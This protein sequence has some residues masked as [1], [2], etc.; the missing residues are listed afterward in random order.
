MRRCSARAGA[1]TPASR[2][3]CR[4][5]AAARRSPPQLQRMAPKICWPR[6]FPIRWRAARTSSAIAKIPDHPLVRPDDRRLP[7]RGDGHR[8][9][10]AACCAT[11][12]AGEIDVRRARPDR[13]LAARARNPD[14]AA[15][16]LSR[17]RAARGAPHAGGDE[18]AAGSTRDGSDLGKLDAEAIAR[19]REEAW[20]EPRN[21]DEL[22][23]ALMWLR[24]PQRGRSRRAARLARRCSSELVGREACDVRIAHGG[25]GCCGCRRAP[26]AIRARCFHRLSARRRSKRP[27]RYREVVDARRCAGRDRARPAR[28]PGARHRHCAGCPARACRRATVEIALARLEGRRLGDARPVQPGCRRKPSGASAAC[29]RASTATPSSACARR[30]SRSKRAI[31]CASCSNGSTSLRKP[32]VEGAGR[33][34]QHRVAARRIRGARCRVGDR[35]SSRTR[36]RI[37]SRMARRAEP[38]RSGRVDA[39]RAAHFKRRARAQPRAHHADCTCVAPQPRHLGCTRAGRYRPDADIERADRWSSSSRRMARRSSTRS[40]KVRPCCARKSSRRWP[41]WSRRG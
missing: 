33:G 10:G 3:R 9:L 23:D 7:A 26:A 20:P 41:S 16:R 40:S 22:H 12:R 15:V 38:R 5:S 28:R 31:S 1:G 21:A 27:T 18:R 14:R 2:W 11:S 17:R 24:L 25:R 37:R 4:A 39:H 34:G 6:C 32:A 8:G 35:D 29:W 13:A 30:S 19:V 36:Q